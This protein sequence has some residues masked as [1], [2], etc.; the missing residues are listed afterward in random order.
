MFVEMLKERWS[1]RSSNYPGIISAYIFVEKA[2][3]NLVSLY[4]SKIQALQERLGVSDAN[5]QLGPHAT[6]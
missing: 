3:A 5:L 6:N 2:D 4:P 1:Q